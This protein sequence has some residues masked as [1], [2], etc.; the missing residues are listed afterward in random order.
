[1]G[2]KFRFV[3]GGNMRRYSML[4]ENMEYKEL[5]QLLGVNGRIAQNE[6]ALL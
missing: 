1:M 4:G 5:G 3:I 6:Y 2:Y